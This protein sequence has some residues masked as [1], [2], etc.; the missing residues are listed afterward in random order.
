MFVNITGLIEVSVA[1]IDNTGIWKPGYLNNDADERPTWYGWQY[2][3]CYWS[4]M[5]AFR[6]EK[7]TLCG[8]VVGTRSGRGIGS[9]NSTIV[10]CITDVHVYL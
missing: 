8:G 3:C 2:I 5:R 7:T 6:M 4:G 10:L 1:I 9:D